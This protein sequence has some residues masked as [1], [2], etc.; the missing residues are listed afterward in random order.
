MAANKHNQW[1]PAGDNAETC[2]TQALCSRRC[3]RGRVPADEL[4]GLDEG[5]RLGAALRAC[6]QP[7]LLAAVCARQGLRQA[8]PWLHGM[9]RADPA[10]P[11]LPRLPRAW[12][13]PLLLR[14]C[15]RGCGLPRELQRALGA[16]LAEQ[17]LPRGGSQDPPGF[18]PEAA[19]AAD[20][21]GRSL[22]SASPEAR[23]RARAALSHVVAAA[24][25]Q[26]GRALGGASQGSVGGAAGEAGGECPWSDVAWLDA[27]AALDPGGALLAALVPNVAAAVARDGDPAVLAAYLRCLAAAAPD[28]AARALAALLQRR[29]LTA[30]ALLIGAPGAAANALG[31]LLAALEAAQTAAA[32]PEAQD[33]VWLARVGA[34][35]SSGALRAGDVDGGLGSTESIVV[36]LDVARAAPLALA[37]VAGVLVG[38]GSTGGLA[39]DAGLASRVR[40][41]VPEAASAGPPAEQPHGR[42]DELR[43]RY[44][45]LVLLMLRPRADAASDRSAGAGEWE[46]AVVLRR[47]GPSPSP[48]PDTLL[49]LDERSAAAAARCPDARLATAGVRALS[50]AGA[51]RLM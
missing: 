25:G 2:Q 43:P 37:T 5:Y 35:A 3:N 39:G 41:D 10:T 23:E 21:L 50:P 17:L 29:P 18:G 26:G 11:A 7:D 16:L 49:L 12:R 1:M 27:L 20:L 40:A 8:W 33:A 34:G 51:A 47:R 48:E 42:V 32:W 13:A 24:G 36:P 45:R 14:L 6:R 22:A 15:A 31:V 19:A 44:E 46:A 38:S 9:L 28:L 30:R 4:F